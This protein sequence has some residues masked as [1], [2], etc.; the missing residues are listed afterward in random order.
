MFAELSAATSSAN[1]IIKLLKTAHEASTQVEINKILFEMQ[2]HLLD[3]QAKLSEAH[4]KM[5]ELVQIERA[6]KAKLIAFENWD[7]EAAKYEL[8]DIGRGCLVMMLKPDEQEGATP[9]WLC[10]NCFEK[11]EK[12]YLNRAST[13]LIEYKCIRCGYRV[14]VDQAPWHGSVL[15]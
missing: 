10:P 2:G 3:L 14:C 13:R 12:S 6:T 5:D 11:H 15:R 9:H 4:Q 7:T 1:A 8:K